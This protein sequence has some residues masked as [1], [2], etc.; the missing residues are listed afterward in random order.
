MRKK[1]MIFD[2]HKCAKHLMTQAVIEK[3]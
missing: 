1:R 3:F 2:T